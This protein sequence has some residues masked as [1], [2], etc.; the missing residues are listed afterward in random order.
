MNPLF[1]TCSWNYD[2]WIDLVYTGKRTSAAEY[3]TEYSQ[4]FRTAEI[5]SWFYKIPDQNEVLEY[6]SFAGNTLRFTCKISRQITL[7]HQRQAKSRS[8]LIDNPYFLSIELFENYLASIE[9][10]LPRVDALILEFEYLNKQKMPSQEHFMRRLDDFA[11]KIQADIPLAVEC[12]NGNYLNKEYF[13]FL[14]ERNLIHVFSEKRYMPHIAEV[15]NR[16]GADLVDSTVIR[17]LGGDR[18]AIEQKTKK[19]WNSIAEPK[20]ELFSITQ[21]IKDLVNRGKRVT[22]NV[23]NHYEGSAPLTINKMRQMLE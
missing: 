12:R 4:K 11:V 9:P 3:L 8:G 14:K 15:Y 22:I 5:D 23:N 2:S 19:L 7:T 20:N 6:L 21:M 10:M 16:F 1:G 17:L 13:Q 18:Q